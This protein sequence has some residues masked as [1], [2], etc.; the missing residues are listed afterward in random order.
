MLINSLRDMFRYRVNQK[1]KKTSKQTKTKTTS[2]KKDAIIGWGYI[3]KTR[4][5]LK[6]NNV[7]F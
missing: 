5:I 6:K 2:N 4:K 1:K 7:H 3:S